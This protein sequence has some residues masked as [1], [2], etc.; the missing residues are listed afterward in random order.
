M[1]YWI[2]VKTKYKFDSEEDAPN[3]ED[4][5]PDSAYDTEIETYE[6]EGYTCFNCHNDFLTFQTFPM[7]V[8]HT[9]KGV[10][11]YYE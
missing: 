8:K 9:A 3:W 1:A 4:L 10:Q 2:E 7:M 5:D 11:I 6:D